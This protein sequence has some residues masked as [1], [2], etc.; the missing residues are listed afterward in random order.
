MDKKRWILTAGI[1]LRLILAPFSYH[2]DVAPFDLAGQVIA[3]GNILN[4]YD[5]LP[6]LPSQSP[7]LK[8]FPPTLFNYPPAV[9]FFLGGS[10]LLLTGWTNPVFHWTFLLQ[11]ENV[12][13]T[14]PVFLHL[15][16]LKLP[17]LVFDLLTAYLLTKLFSSQR[18]KLLAMTFWIFNPVNIYAT[19]LMGQFDVIPNFF[20]M[21]SLVLLTKQKELTFSRIIMA[22]IILGIGAAFKIYPLFLLIPLASLSKGFWPRVQICLVG[23]LPYLLTILPFLS[24]RGFRSTALVAGQTL[25]SFYPQIPIS[26]GESILLFL[27]ALIFVYLIFLTHK[28][29]PENIWQYFFV[30]MLLFFI[31]THYHP[32]WFLW[33]TP[34]LILDLIKSNFKNTLPVLLSIIS[35]TGLVF[36][37][38]PG[39]S[40]GL[41]SP[42]VPSLYHIPSIWQL[43]HL[44]PDY[45][46]SRSVFQTFFV[47]AAFYWFYYYN[48]V[49]KR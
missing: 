13:G 3:Q 44:N 42:L 27:A 39:L 17:Y 20:V 6:S 24:S 49:V 7:I 28:I 32:Q 31:F 4:Y 15:L 25:K 41:F 45:N 48:Q 47:G 14:F 11:V 22:A 30:T 34:F 29:E 19:Y 36:F 12:L 9:Y 18:D 35:F 21:L 23:V 38:D 37:F 46:L 2:S 43:L 40:I 10:S 26:G 8:T 16:L 5:Y 33:L 1:I